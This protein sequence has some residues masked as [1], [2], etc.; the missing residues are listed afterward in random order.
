MQGSVTVGN[1]EA[2]TMHRVA[3]ECVNLVGEQFGR[4]LDWS[5]A[6]LG[7]LDEVCA[8]LTADG[9]LAGQR[10]ELWWQLIGAYAGEVTIRL[11]EGQ[12][13]IDDERGPRISA[14]GIT[15]FPFSTARRILSGEQ[16]KSLASF[17][18]A[19]PAIAEHSRQDT[20]PT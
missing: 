18:R 19:L 15:G 7:A 1:P 11:Y 2:E 16:N 4:Q 5:L 13:I 10:L 3:A 9:P 17:A 20:T 12:W 14:L 8:Q 6:S